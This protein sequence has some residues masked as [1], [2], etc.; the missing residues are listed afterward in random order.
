MAEEVSVLREFRDRYLL[1]NTVGAILV[2][3][4]YRYSPW[5][6][7]F[8]EGHELPRMAVR[9]LLSPVVKGC[10]ILLMQAQ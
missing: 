8:L 7:S 9:A 2:A 3:V 10:R 4:Y 1:T 5:L 6:A